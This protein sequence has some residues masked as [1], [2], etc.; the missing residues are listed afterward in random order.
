MSKSTQATTTLIP[1]SNHAAL[2]LPWGPRTIDRRIKEDPDFPQIIRLGCRRYVEAEALEH[3]RR[4]LV[5]RGKATP[6][7]LR[8]GA[9]Q[10]SASFSLDAAPATAADQNSEMTA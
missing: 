3:Y 8:S 2:N 6:P 5:E 7:R 9:R 10:Q 1:L 4:V